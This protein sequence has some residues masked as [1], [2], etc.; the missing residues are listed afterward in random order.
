MYHVP[1]AI[2]QQRLWSGSSKAQLFLRICWTHG[3]TRFVILKSKYNTIRHVS[4]Q[5]N[6]VDRKLKH[7]NITITFEDTALNYWTHFSCAW[8]SFRNLREPLPA[9]NSEGPECHLSQFP[10]HGISLQRPRTEKKFCKKI[11][12]IKTNSLSVF[13]CL[14]FYWKH[15]T[16]QCFKVR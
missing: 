8:Q 7:T 3:H 11:K 10:V 2:V 12:L 9:D 16:Q 4:K 14:I 1:L 5:D 15:G 13:G 6:Q